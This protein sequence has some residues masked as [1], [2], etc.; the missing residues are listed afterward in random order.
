MVVI[1]CTQKLLKRMGE[2][3]WNPER[4][5]SGPSTTRLGDWFATLVHAD[6]L[7]FI[8]LV[9]E[10]TRLPVV[11]RARNAKHLDAHLIEQLPAVLG[12]LGVDHV[13]ISDEI[14]EMREHR[15][16]PTYN[17]SLD[18]IVEEFAYFLARL[19]EE[20]PEC[21][22]A[23]LA[24]DLAEVPLPVRGESVRQ[25]TLRAFSNEPSNQPQVH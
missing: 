11:V 17:Q 25:L 9:A 24:L 14:D 19:V 4:S 23:K 2:P 13:A 5:T 1:R 20:D 21:G 15:Y 16:A 18:G 10:R 12:A 3:L 22:L 6:R 8:L 7:Q